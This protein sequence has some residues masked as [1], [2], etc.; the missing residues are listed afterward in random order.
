[1]HHD[2]HH[3]ARAWERRRGRSRHGPI[4]QLLIAWA[5]L[6]LILVAYLA[7]QW[8]SAPFGD[9]SSGGTN[10]LG[11]PLNVV[12]PADADRALFGAVPLACCEGASSSES[13]SSSV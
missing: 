9:G 6:S 10:R 4:A 13:E 3:A 5:P 1:M 7:A 8:V 11:L 12:G 2:P